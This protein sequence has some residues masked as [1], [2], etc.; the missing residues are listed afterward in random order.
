MAN[1]SDLVSGLAVVTGVPE[2]TVFAYGRF[3]REAGLIAQRGRGRGA[4]TMEPEDAANLLIAVG[5]TAVTR[6]GGEAIKTYRPMRGT[7]FDFEDSLRDIFLTWLEPLGLEIVDQGE[8]GTLYGLKA[9]FGSFLQFLICE[10]GRGGLVKL[11]RRIP[12]AE[13]PGEL[14]VEWKRTHSENLELSL[15]LLIDRGLLKPKPA[16]QVVMGEDLELA[17]TFVRTGPRV[18]VEFKR[19]WDSSQTVFQLTFEPT[20][21]SRSRGGALR[22][23]AEF[24]HDA[25]VAL[26][27]VLTNHI[28]P[29]L[30]TPR[31][32]TTVYERQSVSSTKVTKR[33]G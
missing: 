17:L 1:L 18:D 3:A 10:A 2:A 29:K 8:F 24:T 33:D 12:V 30:V 13:L 7:I 31:R 26:G 28:D 15:D 32:L 22:V 6:E 9:D 16:E 25:L 20:K 14:W 21:R 11:M 19:M 4:A 27:M 23:S 5:G